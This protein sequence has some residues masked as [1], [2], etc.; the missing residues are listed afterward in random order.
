M[1]PT[2]PIFVLRMVGGF[3]PQGYNIAGPPGIVVTADGHVYQA[4]AM[5]AI[6]PGPMLMPIDA[7]TITPA[8]IQRLLHAAE[9]AG[10]FATAPN[11]DEVEI[12]VTDAGTTELTITT[13]AGTVVH[14][15]TALGMS[16]DGS[17]KEVTPERERLRAFVE[18]LNVL[19][20]VVGV[21]NLTRPTG[22]VPT[23]YRMVAFPANPADY[24]DPATTDPAMKPATQHEQ[25]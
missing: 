18:S 24:S 17:G 2:T 21:E 20:S 6:Y 7:R 9:A 1:D 22:F 16:P 15:A 25:S 13:A 4:G 3:V 19:E 5:V 12:G 14:S 10:L 23:E 8:G 11:Y